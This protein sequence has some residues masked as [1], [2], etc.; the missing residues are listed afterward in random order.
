MQV[1]EKQKAL[2]FEK[3]L[4]DEQARIWKYDTDHFHRQEK[5]IQNCVS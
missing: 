2:A 5:E 4:D 1:E 3:T